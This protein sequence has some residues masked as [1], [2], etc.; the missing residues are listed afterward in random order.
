[1]PVSQPI[2]HIKH[3]EDENEHKNEIVESESQEENSSD[4]E[5]QELQEQKI[6]DFIRAQ[7]LLQSKKRKIKILHPIKEEDSRN[8]V[9]R[10]TYKS[11]FK[12]C[13]QDLKEMQIGHKSKGYF[14]KSPEKLAAIIDQIN[15][16]KSQNIWA[17]NKS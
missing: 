17:S 10:S 3:V 6:E 13:H 16:I 1:M 5:D 9:S 2:H 14:F 8:S 15:E 7:D 4:P 11:T 12:K